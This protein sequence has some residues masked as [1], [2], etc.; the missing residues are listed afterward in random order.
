MKRPRSCYRLS[1]EVRAACLALLKEGK[2]Q[3]E[4]A[5]EL[6]ISPASVYGI[7]EA[8]GMP[9]T[10]RGRGK[11]HE[12]DVYV[13]RQRCRCGL[14]LFTDEEKRQGHCNN[15]LPAEGAVAYM[16][17]RDEPVIGGLSW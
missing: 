8:A 3:K 1:D 5:A 12:A 4:C 14:S 10:N 2:T 6:A 15:C 13:E 9:A 7:R 11:R 16:G 17:R